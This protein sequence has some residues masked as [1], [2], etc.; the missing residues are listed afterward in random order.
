MKLNTKSQLIDT[1]MYI[2]ILHIYE[3]NNTKIYIKEQML[4]HLSTDKRIKALIG[5][6]LYCSKLLEQIS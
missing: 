4:I 1:Y 6:S 2:Y 3:R 5:L